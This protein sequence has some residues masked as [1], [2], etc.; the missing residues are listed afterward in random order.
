MA[1]GDQPPVGLL[2]C[3]NKNEALVEYATGDMDPNLFVSEYKL[4][5]PTKEK[6]SKWLE[7]DLENSKRNL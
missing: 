1:E 3:T 6:L 4:K 7:K 2:F 5:L